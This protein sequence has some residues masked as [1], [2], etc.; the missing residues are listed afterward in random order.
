[1][2]KILSVRPNQHIMS[3]LFEIQK[4]LPKT[5]RTEIINLAIAKSINKNEN[6]KMVS[7]KATIYTKT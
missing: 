1:M 4:Y 2:F 6:W 3:L 5:N 7:K